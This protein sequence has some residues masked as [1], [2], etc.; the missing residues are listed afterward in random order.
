MPAR[1]DDVEIEDHLDVARGLQGRDGLADRH[2]FGQGED[3]RVH[4]AAG[5]LF[6]VFEQV[7]DLAR[8]LAAHQFEHG[9]RQL[10]GQVVDD[11][12]RVV[13]GQLLDELGDLF[14][15]A[16]REQLRARLGAEL[17]EGLHGEPAVAFDEHG[18]RGQAIAFGKLAENLREVGGML[19]LQEIRQVGR[20]ANPEQALH[21]V[22]DEIDLPLRWHANPLL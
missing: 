1:I 15:R 8:F 22:Q 7:L 21:R 17:A 3:M 13:G 4:D 10:F 5:R 6:G 20:R 18:E 12:R 11:G 14:G 19:F 16:A 2:V 9:R